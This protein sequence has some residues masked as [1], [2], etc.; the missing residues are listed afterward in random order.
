MIDDEDE[1][2]E[3]MELMME[4]SSGMLEQLNDRK[5]QLRGIQAYVSLLTAV[6][7]VTLVKKKKVLKK[8]QGI[9]RVLPA[10]S[11]PHFKLLIYEGFVF[12]AHTAFIKLKECCCPMVP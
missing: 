11:H 3:M 12:I 8:T 5:V 9:K 6:P 10:M 7:S 1:F 2:E 4:I